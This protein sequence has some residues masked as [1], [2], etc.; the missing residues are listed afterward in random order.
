AHEIR[1]PLTAIKGFLQLM[2]PTM[3]EN[4]H[5]FEIVFSELSRIELILSELL[6]LAKPQQNAVKER[7][8]LKKIISEVTALLE[9]QA[10]L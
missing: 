6:M 9:T 1:N 8:N 3:E 10:N 4:E 7:V 2:K 5:Y